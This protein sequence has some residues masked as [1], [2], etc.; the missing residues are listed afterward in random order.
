MNNIKYK[1]IAL[2][3]SIL[4]TPLSAYAANINNSDFQS[5][6]FTGWSQDVDGWGAPIFGLNDFSIV[7]PTAGNYAGRIEADYWSTLGDTLS[8]PQDEVWYANTLYQELDLSASA[9]QDLVLSFDWT[10]SGQETAFNENFLVALGDG[11]GDYYGADG[12]LGFLLNP[13]AYGAG[14]FSATLDSSFINALGWSLEFQ[15]N[16]GFDGFGSF[17][18]IDNVSLTAVSQDQAANNVPEPA[19]IWLM[20]LGL[21]GLAKVTRRNKIA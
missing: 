18:T 1:Q 11:I 17:A 2:I 5:N 15:M 16:S 10:F 20:G 9:G 7:E 21:M 14:T 3:S 13:T 6:D 19:V 4:L 12:G 8:T